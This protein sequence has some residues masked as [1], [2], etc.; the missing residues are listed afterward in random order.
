MNLLRP[1][2]TGGGIVGGKGWACLGG[3]AGG[4]AVIVG[5]NNCLPQLRQKPSP[6]AA[7][8]PHCGQTVA[9]KVGSLI[10]NPR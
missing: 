10:P 4:G 5:A 7:G 2:F 9:F 8:A 6:G 3:T 1:F